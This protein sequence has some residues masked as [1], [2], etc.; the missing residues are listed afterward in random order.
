MTTSAR[1]SVRM[2]ASIWFEQSFLQ[3]ASIRPRMLVS[4]HQPQRV[5]NLAA[6]A[7]QCMVASCRA[8]FTSPAAHEVRTHLLAQAVQSGECRY[9]SVD[10]AFRVCLPLLG[11]VQ[12]KFNDPA[13]VRACAPFQDS[14]RSIRTC[15]YMTL[16][17]CHMEW[18][19]NLAV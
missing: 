4:V 2:F 3:V 14:T 16:F 17:N 5:C 7:Q 19:N 13:S 6:D 15:D 11:H 18:E 9:L 1:A 8:I 10:G 12:A